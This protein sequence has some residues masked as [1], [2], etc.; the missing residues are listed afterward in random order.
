MFFYLLLLLLWPSL[1]N[2]ISMAIGLHAQANAHKDRIKPIHLYNISI[3]PLE[4]VQ[5]NKII[6]LPLQHLKYYLH[7][8]CI[9]KQPHHP[10]SK[11][12]TLLTTKS[13]N[14]K[15]I[16]K[17]AHIDLNFAKFAIH[18]KPHQSHLTQTKD[19]QSIYPHAK[20]ET[21][22]VQHAYVMN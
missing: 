1:S 19:I 10:H 8:Y 22:M 4:I 15:E 7:Q 12:T 5:K 18:G 9:Y 20:F 13:P 17:W 2:F 21:S 3:I 11:Q 14:S 6:E 16:A